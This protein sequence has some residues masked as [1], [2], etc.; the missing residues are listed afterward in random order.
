M[1][2]RDSVENFQA[3]F[4]QSVLSGLI[5][6]YKKRMEKK[7]EAI[8]KWNKEAESLSNQVQELSAKV[9]KHKKALDEVL[10]RKHC[11]VRIIPK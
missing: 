10:L 11:S 5:L 8:A 6:Q 7:K 3:K 1:M 9:T 4:R 2:L